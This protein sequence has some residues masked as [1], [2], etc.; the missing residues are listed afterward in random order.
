MNDAGIQLPKLKGPAAGVGKLQTGSPA[1]GARRS[2][3]P[4]LG[5]SQSQPHVGRRNDL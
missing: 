3:L 2:L 1:H 5:H 4:Q